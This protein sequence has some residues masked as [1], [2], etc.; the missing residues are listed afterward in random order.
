VNFPLQIDDLILRNSRWTHLTAEVDCISSTFLKVTRKSKGKDAGKMEVKFKQVACQI[1]L[2]MPDEVYQK[3]IEWMDK[4]A[5]RTCLVPFLMI[6][7]P[8]DRMNVE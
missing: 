5:V 6:L 3:A 8:T 1:F 7:T 4:K 2:Q